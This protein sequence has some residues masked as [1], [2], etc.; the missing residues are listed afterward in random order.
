MDINK[1]TKAIN[2]WQSLKKKCSDNGMDF[3]LSVSDVRALISKKR[4]HYTGRKIEYGI[5]H[6]SLDR[7]DSSL[8]Y[9]KGNVVACHGE[10]NNFKSN[11][12][13]DEI[14]KILSKL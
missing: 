5:S 6:F 7:K 11:L 8:G 2:R 13:K 10:V 12:S 4:C 1:E 14:E 9:I 3:N